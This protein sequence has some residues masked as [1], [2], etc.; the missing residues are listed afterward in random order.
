[1]KLV[2]WFLLQNRVFLLH[3]DLAVTI[4]PWSYPM[5]KDISQELFKHRALQM[6]FPIFLQFYVDKQNHWTFSLHCF[7]EVTFHLNE[8]G[9][10]WHVLQNLF[11]KCVAGINF[12]MCWYFSL[13]QLRNLKQLRKMNMV[14]KLLFLFTFPRFRENRDVISFLTY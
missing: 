11:L 10:L 4:T 2:Q 6:K 8:S 3:V 14:L 12:K 7:K 13:F 1:M 5:L 9:S